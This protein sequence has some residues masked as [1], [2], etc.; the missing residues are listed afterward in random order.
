MLGQTKVAR[1]DTREQA[2]RI[3]KKLEALQSRAN[4]RMVLVREINEIKEEAMKKAD[5]PKPMPPKKNPKGGGKGPK[6]C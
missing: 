5:Y 6:P 2:D 1:L 3:L 4:Q